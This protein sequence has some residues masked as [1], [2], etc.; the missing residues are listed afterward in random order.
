[1]LTC[2]YRVSGSV[3]SYVKSSLEASWPELNIPPVPAY[4]KVS[5][6]IHPRSSQVLAKS[7]LQL[8][9]ILS[10]QGRLLNV[11]PQLFS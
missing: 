6:N 5:R 7:T 10:K 11:I 8:R 3:T 9:A 2:L 1:M 4:N